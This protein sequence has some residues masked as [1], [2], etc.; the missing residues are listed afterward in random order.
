MIEISRPGISLSPEGVAFLK[1]I[2]ARLTWGE[3]PS[4]DLTVSEYNLFVLVRRAADR[5]RF[6]VEQR[7]QALIHG[8]VGATTLV[9]RDGLWTLPGPG[10][11]V[12]LDLV[13]EGIKP[14]DGDVVVIGT[15]VDSFT[16]AL[17]AFS[18]A[19]HLVS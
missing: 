6:G 7:D 14:S 4:T 11:E 18:A 2:E 5:V 12:N 1:A 3:F 10:G 16:A 15:G 19:F 8:A 13:E 9:R 17:G